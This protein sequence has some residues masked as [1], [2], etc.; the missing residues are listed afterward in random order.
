MKTC[1]D[2]YAELPEAKAVPD[3]VWECDRIIAH[4]HALEDAIRLETIALHSAHRKMVADL[5]EHWS[6][7][8]IRKVGLIE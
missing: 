5:R 7:D 8:E 3:S 6:D 1:R 2:R 4:I